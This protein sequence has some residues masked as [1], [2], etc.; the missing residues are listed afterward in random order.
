MNSLESDLN[1]IEHEINI[2]ETNDLLGNCNDPSQNILPILY[3]K[4][5]ALQ[6]QNSIMWAQRAR[7]QR[8]RLQRVNNGD[9]NTIFFIILSVFAV[10][11]ITSRIFL[12]VIFQPSGG[13]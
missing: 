12:I 2:A 11:L 10:K 5:C 3:D 7:L 13:Y 6:K 4:Y 8:A 1:E 9:F